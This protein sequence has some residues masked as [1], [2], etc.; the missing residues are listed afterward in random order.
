MNKVIHNKVGNIQ[1]FNE[2]VQRNIITV[3]RWREE[4]AQQKDIPV[5]FLFDN[6]ALYAIA[7]I[8]PT[9]HDDFVTPEIA[10]LNSS[11]KNGIIK[12]IKASNEHRHLTG[13][14]KYTTK[15]DDETINKIIHFFNS[16][17]DSYSFDNT[18]VASKKD[19]QSL[20]YNLKLENTDIN[21]KLLKGWRYEVVGK[22]LKEFIL[23]N[24]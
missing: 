6:K 18:S 20:I 1:K 3:A 17:L 2:K 23:A 13:E 15:I 5:R 24:L 7:G 12:A 19:I 16:E 8:A 9:S 21:N 10:R 4:T 11:I 14:R 22:K